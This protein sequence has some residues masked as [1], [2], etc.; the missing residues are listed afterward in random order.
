MKYIFRVACYWILHYSSL[1]NLQPLLWYV[2]AFLV[3]N[4]HFVT[5]LIL[6]GIY[7]AHSLLFVN[8]GY[9][10]ITVR[11]IIEVLFSF[12]VPVTVHR[13]QSV[14]REKTNKMQQSDVYYQRLS[15]HVSGIIMPIFRRTKTVCYCM[16]CTALVLLD[17]VGS[18]CGALRYRMRAPWRL[19]FEQ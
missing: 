10:C 11:Y 8:M 2:K 5:L 19:L 3:W 18:G 17:V 1:F 14:K 7:L 6:Q 15:Q 9:V 16:W 13:E 4:V 12:Q